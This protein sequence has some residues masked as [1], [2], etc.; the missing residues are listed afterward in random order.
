MDSGVLNEPNGPGSPGKGGVGPVPR[1][2]LTMFVVLFL[3]NL[4]DYIDRWV[5]AAVLP[6]VQAD[7]KLNNTRAGWLTTLFLIS[8]SLISPVMGFAGDRMRRTWLLGLGVGLWSLATV[9]TGLA[10]TYGQLQWARAFLGIGEATYGV[11]AP[12]M[13]MD[14]FSRDVRARVLSAFYLAMPIGGALGMLLGAWIAKHYN[15]HIA[16]FAVGAPGLLVALTAFLLPEPVRG[17]SEGVDP[18]RLEEHARAGASRE[19]YLELLVNSSYNY[20]VFGMTFYT[21]AIGGLASWFPTFLIVTKGIEPVEATRLLGLTT[22][23]A[24]VLGTSLGGWMADHLARWSPRALFLV[25]GVAL[26]AAA[27]FTL[28]AI[29][30]QSKTTI[31]AGIFLSEALMFINTGPCNAVIANVVM[32][33][34]RA[35][36]YAIATFVVH[37]LGDIWS[38]TLMGWVADFFGHE[39][40]MAS[41]F[42]RLLA[43][44]GA[45]PTVREG[46]D[47]ENLIA[48]M[49]VVIP[50]IVL[51]GVVLL[52]GARHLP[53]EMALMLARLKAK[54][55]IAEV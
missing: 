5:L 10:Q 36:A 49:L 2:A 37:V 9:G 38:P 22:V 55:H 30:G 13:L 17:A 42:G 24:A 50:A 34:M 14:V 41:S 6:Q 20:S 33:N 46:G 45:L 51:A 35:A 23:G 40:A 7:L 1:W 15:W 43:A 27:P 31:Y 18:K 54:P 8:Y 52:V 28:L 47:A 16:F 29:Y 44:L 48:G 53:R 32:P 26:I 4:L 19:D 12:A 39:D 11:I 25:P 21:F 3:M